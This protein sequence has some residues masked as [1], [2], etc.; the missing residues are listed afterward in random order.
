MTGPGYTF[1]A[2]KLTSY[3]YQE[4]NRALIY[5]SG[6]DRRTFLQGLITNDIHKVSSEKSIYSALLTPQGKFLHDFFIYEDKDSLVLDTEFHRQ[7]E[8]I[9]LLTKYK[10]RSDVTITPSQ[11][12]NTVY[13]LY[14]Q[15]VSADLGLEPQE[16]AT[17][18]N[19][20]SIFFVDPR[21]KEMGVRLISD[22][23]AVQNY[24]PAS[25][26][27]F[28]KQRLELGIPR[29]GI[30]MLIDKAIP[31]ECGLD[32]LHAI[33][34][35]K[36]C[37]MGQELTSR[38]KYRG[39]VRKRLLPVEFEGAEL[40]PMTSLSYEGKEMGSMRSSHG[41]KGIALIRLEVFEGPQKDVILNAGALNIRP[42]IPKWVKFDNP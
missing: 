35:Q 6:P 7:E 3:F 32:E 8:L 41:G 21:L 5:M 13:C 33:D 20:Q 40:E 17:L 38:T 42:V 19:D 15:N 30:D 23:F 37:Y 1:G 12:S 16:G 34:W 4:E 26:S 31:L 11:G 2:Y 27:D 36:G 9:N 28:E 10:L 29:Q 39:L 24:T 14:G 18:R 22:S 25:F